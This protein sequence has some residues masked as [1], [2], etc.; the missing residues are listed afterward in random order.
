MMMLTLMLQMRLASKTWI[1]RA[2]SAMLLMFIVSSFLNFGC[3]IL[4]DNVEW[5]YHE[6]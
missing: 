5:T 1:E 3:N 2:N 6:S 4:H